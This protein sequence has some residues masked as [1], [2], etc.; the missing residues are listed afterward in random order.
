MCT[1][2]CKDFSEQGTSRK[3]IQLYSPI[4]YLYHLLPNPLAI[5]RHQLFLTSRSSLPLFPLPSPPLPSPPLPSPPLPSPPLPLFSSLPPLQFPSFSPPFS[6]MYM[7]LPPFLF[8]SVGRL[9]RDL[10]VPVTCKI[11]VFDDIQKTVQYAKMLEAAGCQVG[12]LL[13]A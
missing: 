9:H 5:L 1:L 6:P 8:S 10:A 4:L 12:V 11:R 7:Y 2:R 13:P 3:A